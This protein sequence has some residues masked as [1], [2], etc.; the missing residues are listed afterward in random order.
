MEV[1]L[2]HP[3]PQLGLVKRHD[4]W[5]ELTTI[6]TIG[7]TSLHAI[8]NYKLI[9]AATR[10]EASPQARLLL[11][12]LIGYLPVDKIE[13]PKSRFIV[14]PG[15]ERLADELSYSKRSIQRLADELEEKGLLR[16][17]YNG[18]NRR[19]GFDITPLAMRHQ[20]IES[21]I[22]AIQTQRKIDRERQQ[23]ELSLSANQIERPNVLSN[24]S[25]QDAISDTHNRSTEHNLAVEKIRPVLDAIPESL[26]SKLTS[27]LSVDQDRLVG[28]EALTEAHIL[29]H[30]TGSGRAAHLGWTLAK[31]TFGFEAAISLVT[32]AEEDP[33]RR[34]STDRYFGWLLRMAI[35]GDGHDIIRQAA[36]RVSTKLNLQPD[37]ISPNQAVPL[38]SPAP[39]TAPTG[40]IGGLPS[41]S[42]F[43]GL[44]VATKGP[45]IDP[46][47]IADVPNVPGEDRSM[48]FWRK[49]IRDEIGVPEYEVCLQ[50]ARLTQRAQ[51]I[52]IT[53][54]TP[55]MSR[56][57]AN[58]YSHIILAAIQT[59]AN[60]QDFKVEYR[61]SVN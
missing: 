8:P 56:Y 30:L 37:D 42:R 6:S 1:S 59:A 11:V 34:S 39:V 53:S 13:N 41:I 43:L 26:K 51:T 28:S 4:D 9:K 61:V 3:V 44:E 54:D 36:D 33:R 15:N 40:A 52:T 60:N 32:I 2:K 16:R 5:E 14:F 48:L 12:H 47:Q 7:R 23:M 20:E 18:V 19:T 22:V 45:D 10:A 27:S 49:A 50:R 57:L 46:S 38:P 21:S 29:K 58:T 35:K 55:T 24:L 31:R 25:S 17:C